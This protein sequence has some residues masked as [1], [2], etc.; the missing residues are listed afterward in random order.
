MASGET[1]GLIL[2]GGQARR[3]GGRDKAFLPFAGSDL[4]HRAIERLASQ[5]DR[6]IIS[7]NREVE[8]FTAL[9]FPVVSEEKPREIIRLGH[10][11]VMISLNHGTPPGILDH[12]AIGLPRFDKDA[13][14]RHLTQR[15]LTVLQGDYAGLHVKDPDGINVQVVQQGQG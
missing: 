10:G 11:R 2:A 3:M 14:T 5:C 4:V 6:V 8:R 7:A 15:G 13:V 9:G 1:I 12:F